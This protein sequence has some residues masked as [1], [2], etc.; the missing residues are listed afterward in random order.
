MTSRLL[1][2]L[3]LAAAGHA[4]AFQLNIRTDNVLLDEATIRAR[5]TAIAAEVGVNIPDDPRVR[6]SVYSRALES[7]IE[8]TKIYLH[9]AQL[10]K[11]FTS[12]APYPFQGYVPIRN[13]E[14]YGV[15]DDAG[16]REKLD[17]TLREFFKIMK[18]MDQGSGVAPE[19]SATPSKPTIVVAP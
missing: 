3:L 7:Q 17:E 18:T 14:R 5:T 15:D 2:L 9:R 11:A 12:A 16:M 8:G 6:I 1:A 19:S 10:T 13:V 4:Q